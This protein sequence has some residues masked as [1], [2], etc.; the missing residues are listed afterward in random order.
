[1]P[2]LSLSAASEAMSSTALTGVVSASHSVLDFESKP[3]NA[4]L[5][6]TPLMDRLKAQEAQQCHHSP[7]NPPG[8]KVGAP[9]VSKIIETPEEAAM[10]RGRI[11]AKGGGDA[12]KLGTASAAK[13]APPSPPSGGSAHEVSRA[14]NTWRDVTAPRTDSSEPQP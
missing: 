1:V 9:S 3:Q 11:K 10:R 14:L 6:R 12:F 4:K 8:R 13:Q 7:D 2:Q 5:K